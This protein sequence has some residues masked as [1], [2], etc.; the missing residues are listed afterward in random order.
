MH[1]K[2]EYHQFLRRAYKKKYKKNQLTIVY[3]AVDVIFTKT[4]KH[5]AFY[6]SKVIWHQQSQQRIIMSNNTGW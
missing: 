5:I 4:F 2:E 1:W 6:L 3:E